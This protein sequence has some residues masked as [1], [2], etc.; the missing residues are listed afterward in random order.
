MLLLFLLAS[1]PP[2]FDIFA[3]VG[4]KTLT[5]VR[6]PCR[7]YKVIKTRVMRHPI[8]ESQYHHIIVN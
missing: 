4:Y 5:D 2:R 3:L 8:A 7:D 1:W 6:W